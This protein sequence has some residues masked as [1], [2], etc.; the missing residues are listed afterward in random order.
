IIGGASI[1]GGRGRIA[2]SCLGTVLT[3]LINK[4]LR[5]GWPT[6]PPVKIHGA[7]VP[8]N[9]LSQLPAG[10][11]PAFLG[12]ILLIAVLIEPFVI[13]RQLAARFWARLRGAPPPP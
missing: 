11:V 5:E 6:T 1:L 13:R 10:A 7:D 9:A 2:G 12:V 4:V 3:V 8:V